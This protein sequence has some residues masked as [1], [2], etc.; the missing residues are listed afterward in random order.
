MP[1]HLIQALSKPGDTVGDPFCGSGTTL[2]EAM[3]LGRAA[4]GLDINPFGILIAEVKCMIAQR[5]GLLSSPETL[6]VLRKVE[7]LAGKHAVRGRI[8]VNDRIPRI[9]QADLFSGQAMLDSSSIEPIERKSVRP[10]I[11]EIKR[12]FHRDTLT[13]L[14]AL[15]R[16]ISKCAD[17]DLRRL[18]VVLFIA[19]LMPASSHEGGKPYGYFADNVVPKTAVYRSAF[20]LFSRRANRLVRR[21]RDISLTP[22]GAAVRFQ[23]STGDASDPR[24][25]KGVSLDCIVTSPPY[26]GAVD[27]STAFRLASYW[28][29]E[30]GGIEQIRTREIG[31]RSL[32]RRP[33]ARE[34][35]FEKMEAAF[36]NAVAS[37]KA[38]GGLA[39]VLPK[40]RSQTP[41]ISRLIKA[42]TASGQLREVARLERRILNRHFVRI[43]GGIR[44]EIVI[45]FL[46]VGKA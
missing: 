10:N 38:G 8:Q 26:P 2:V 1:A 32:R 3:L 39:V 17:E 18:L 11:I 34:V 20:K 5:P 45:A 28:F 25:W 36:I 13:E 37:L 29:P 46:K 9:E 14:L 23:T 4:W 33:D 43:G 40:G 21:Y 6:E 35:Y 31:P 15:F 27:Y 22:G 24:A 41:T 42:L 19:T 16:I 30:L 12:W 7:R 44:S